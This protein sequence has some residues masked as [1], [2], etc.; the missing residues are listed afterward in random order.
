MVLSL[1]FP[2]AWFWQLERVV[3]RGSPLNLPCLF[4]VL[5]VAPVVR[6]KEARARSW[7]ASISVAPKLWRFIFGVDVMSDAA[8]LFTQFNTEPSLLPFGVVGRRRGR[9]RRNT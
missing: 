3:F 2:F 8:S 4:Y 1:S 5:C 9:R 6:Y 7:T